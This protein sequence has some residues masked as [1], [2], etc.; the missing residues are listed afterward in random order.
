MSRLRPLA[1]A[2]ALVAAAAVGYSIP[3]PA[4][5]ARIAAPVCA[6]Q[7]AVIDEAALRAALRAELGNLPRATANMAAAAPVATPPPAPSPAAAPSAE[8]ASAF[9]DAERLLD[10]ALARHRWGSEEAHAFRQLLARVDSDSRTQLLSE[11]APAINDG[12]LELATS[13]MPF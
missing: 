12:R 9:A 10:G 11:L 6:K 1:S 7:T 2:A 13:G 3:R 8:A 5:P 4:A